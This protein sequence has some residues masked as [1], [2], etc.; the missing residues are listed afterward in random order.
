MH[1]FAR[2]SFLTGIARI[3]DPFGTLNE[4]NTSPNARIADYYAI[5]SD[6]KAVGDDLRYSIHEH[7]KTVSS[8]KRR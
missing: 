7:K 5:L 2:P 4:Y 3:I 1:L 6:W 8:R